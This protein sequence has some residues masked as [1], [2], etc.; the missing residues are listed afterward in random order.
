MAD[1]LLSK[2]DVAERQLLQAISMFFRDEDP[3]SIHALSES[4]SRTLHGLIKKNGNTK[5]ISDGGLIKE[6]AKDTLD[7]LLSESRN[8]HSLLDQ[9]PHT[10]RTFKPV[11]NH[12]SLI[13]SVNTHYIMKKKYGPETF[14][15]LAWYN[16]E[17]PDH[18]REDPSYA[19][20]L[21][22]VRRALPEQQDMQAWSNL[23]RMLR[24]G[25]ILNK[26]ICLAYG[27]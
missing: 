18:I 1:L 17:Y 4:A 7:R 27:L 20:M 6:G 3:V 16:R 23:I 22:G 26:R 19:D 5:F 24:R 25:R 9:D 11:F 12:A 14:V 10:S 2:F 15:F 8:F 21:E 13:T